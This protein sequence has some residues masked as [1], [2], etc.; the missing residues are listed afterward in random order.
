ML[1]IDL[2]SL[3]F[4][5]LLDLIHQV[6]GQFFVSQHP[7][8]VMGVSGSIHQRL[9]SPQCIPLMGTDVLVPGERVLSRLS[10]LRCDNNLPLPLDIFPIGDRPGNLADDGELLGFASLEKFGHS[11]QT[12]RNVFGLCR[13]SRNLNQDVPCLNPVPLGNKD[14]RSDRQEVPCS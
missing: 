1:V 7:E 12:A 4:V 8:N 11:G 3:E 13:F 14:I 10:D 6:L 9:T 2:D 5:D